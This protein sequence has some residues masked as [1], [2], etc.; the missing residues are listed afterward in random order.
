MMMKRWILGLNAKHPEEKQKKNL[1]K[2]CDLPLK[3]LRIV[4]V[5]GVEVTRR[6]NY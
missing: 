2:E 3:D 5:R 1:W 6:G 4:Y